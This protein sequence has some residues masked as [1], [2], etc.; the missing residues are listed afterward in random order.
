MD[1]TKGFKN[2]IVLK[3]TLEIIKSLIEAIEKKRERG[4]KYI[5]ERKEK[6]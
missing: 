6:K 3:G 5:R 2:E 1:V 4:H